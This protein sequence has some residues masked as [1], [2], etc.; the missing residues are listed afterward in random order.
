MKSTTFTQRTV[1]RLLVMT[2]IVSVSVV[3]ASDSSV[4][5]ASFTTENHLS[6]NNCPYVIITT[7]EFRDNFKPLITDRRARFRD[8]TNTNENLIAVIVT[9]DDDYN[10]DGPDE[11]PKKGIYGWYDGTR[12]DGRE[13]Q[14]NLRRRPHSNAFLGRRPGCEALSHRGHR[15]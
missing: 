5:M 7:S 1:K 13:G 6:S 10:G 15:E 2:C 4:S 3:F 14:T 11:G 8:E 12:P 9:V